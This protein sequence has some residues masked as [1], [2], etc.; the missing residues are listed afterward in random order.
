LQ[1][2]AAQQ[3]QSHA[4]ALILTATTRFWLGV[5][6]NKRRRCGAMAVPAWLCC[7]VGFAC[8]RSVLSLLQVGVRRWE[9][10]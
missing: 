9:T 5:R 10:T 3:S 7:A 1:G 4:L 8:Y 6:A 2:R